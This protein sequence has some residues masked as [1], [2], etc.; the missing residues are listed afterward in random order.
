MNSYSGGRFMRKL[1]SLLHYYCLKLTPFLLLSTISQGTAH[2]NSASADSLTPVSTIAKAF[3]DKQS[4][5]Q[6]KQ[7]GVITK[8]LSDDTAGDRHQRMIVRLSNNQTLLITHNIDLAPRV[9]NPVVGKTLTFYGEYE[10][11]EEGGVV[12]WTHKDPDGKHIAGWLEYDGKRYSTLN[13]S[14]IDKKPTISIN[15]EGFRIDEKINRVNASF[16]ISGRLLSTHSPQVSGINVKKSFTNS[17]RIL[18]VK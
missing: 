12:H 15:N 2:E 7:K 11:N 1:P 18:S 16:S 5:I 13:S 3:S 17:R 6:V 4:N 9:P 14:V 8:V 10:W